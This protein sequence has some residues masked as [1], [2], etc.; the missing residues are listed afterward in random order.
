[1]VTVGVAKDEQVDV[2][3]EE[4]ELFGELCENAV[5]GAAIN[6]NVVLLRRGDEGGIALAYVQEAH[7]EAA[8][9]VEQ[10]I[11]QAQGESEGE[12]GEA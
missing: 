1:M 10:V 4:G 7:A 8:A 3:E 11:G 5:A 9:L 6:E 2:A 12:N